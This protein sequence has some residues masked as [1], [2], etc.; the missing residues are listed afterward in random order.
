[1]RIKILKASKKKITQLNP[2]A[3]F[4][5]N[6]NFYMLTSDEEIH[7]V[8]LETGDIETFGSMTEIEEKD[9]ELT[10]SDLRS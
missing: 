7:A 4:T 5:W 10:I 1:M 2:G 8:N 6:D 3:V 9:A